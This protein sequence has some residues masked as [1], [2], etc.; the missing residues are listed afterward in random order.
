MTPLALDYYNNK[1]KFIQVNLL[2][3]LTTVFL[4][5]VN[6]RYYYCFFFFFFRANSKRETVITRCYFSLWLKRKLHLLFELIFPT[7]FQVPR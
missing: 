1:S 2:C 4:E 7:D 3:K 5:S 6:S